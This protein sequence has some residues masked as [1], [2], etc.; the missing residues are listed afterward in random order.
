MKFKHLIAGCVTAIGLATGVSAETTLR[1]ATVA[2]TSSPWGQ[3][4]LGVAEKIEAASNGQLKLQFI[5]DAKLGDEQTILRQGMKGRVD[6]A[7]VSNIPLTLIGQEID[8]LSTPFLFDSVEQ[9]TCVAT[10]HMGAVLEDNLKD[11]GLHPLTSMEVGHY[12]VFTKD[13]VQTPEDLEGVKVRTAATTSDENFARRLGAV[14]VPLGTSDT[15][16]ALQTGNVDAAF[17]PGLYGLA[18]GTHKVAPHIAVTNHTRLIGTIA[19]SQRSYKKLSDQEK[20]W[21]KIFEQ[22][23]AS[24]SALI[25]GAEAGLLKKV[26]D[27]GVPIARL[28]DEQLA[29]WRTQSEG[30]REE[31]AAKYGAKGQAIL[32]KIEAAKTACKS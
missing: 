21:L 11:A 14:G 12:V 23:G 17:L 22:E 8:L 10:Q 27:A 30:L 9:G 18:I 20:E 13:P 3:W 6:I 31:L 16:P 7:M 29:Q 26:E 28:S 32:D 24:M 19:I 15:I 4:A 5:G 25:L 2:P 1:M